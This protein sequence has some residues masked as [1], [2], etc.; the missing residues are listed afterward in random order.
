LG[1]VRFGIADLV[2]VAKNRKRQRFAER[3]ES[4]EMPAAVHDELADCDLAGLLQCIADDR[5][6]FIGLITIRHEVVGLF[7]I[8]GVDFCLID[9]T[10]HVDGVLGLKLEFIKLLRVD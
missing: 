5:V 1:K 10:H 6:S 9:E 7:P 2:G 3:L 4:N 8:T